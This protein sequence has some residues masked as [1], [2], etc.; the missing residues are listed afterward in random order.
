MSADGRRWPDIVSL[1]VVLVAAAVA[2]L[3]RLDLVEFKQDEAEALNNAWAMVSTGVIPLTAPASSTGI[4]NSPVITWLLGIPTLLGLDGAG[5]TGFLAAFTVAAAGLTWWVARRAWGTW[6]ALLAGLVVGTAFWTTIHTRKAWDVGLVPFFVALFLLCC[7][8]WL[9]DGSRWW[10]VGAAAA[11]AGTIQFHIS[12]VPQVGVLAIL[13]LA[14][15]WWRRL[16]WPQLVAGAGVVVLAFLPAIVAQALRGFPALTT[17]SALA[18]GPARIDTTSIQLAFSALGDTR[19]EILFGPAGVAD[20]GGLDWA[21]GLV[22]AATVTG[23]VLALVLAVP[24]LRRRTLPDDTATRAAVTG[25]IAVVA[26]LVPVLFYARY[27]HPLQLH[28]FLQVVPPAALLLAGLAAWVAGLG[29]RD[30]RTFAEIG[31]IALG[32]AFAMVQIG[33]LFQVLD[34][35]QT[36]WTEGGYAV[37][38][39]AW[40][41][42]IG[43]LADAVPPGAT[44]AI[45]TTPERH[46]V[47]GYFARG[48]FR[49]VFPELTEVAPARVSGD[50]LYWAA[51]DTAGPS[52]SAP[53]DIVAEAPLP[54]GRSII[55]TRQPT[56]PAPAATSEPLARFASGVD[57]LSAPLPERWTTGE[58]AW[59]PLTWRV[60]DADPARDHRFSVKLVSQAN[61]AVLAERDGIGWDPRD[62]Q[63]G[64]VVTTWFPLTPET[65]D[66]QGP[67]RL[68]IAMY[69]LQEPSRVT[70][71]AGQGAAFRNGVVTLAGPTRLEIPRGLVE[72]LPA[73][74]AGFSNGIRLEGAGLAIQPDGTATVLLGWSTTRQES[75]D[76]TVFVQALDEAGALE[77]Q[78]DGQPA[79]GTFPT[80]AWRPGELVLD[81]HALPWRP[82]QRLIAGLYDGRTGERVRLDSGAD[83]AELPVPGR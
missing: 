24:V 63:P 8:R 76:L 36:T 16:G 48:Q 69:T 3:A 20:L 50:P 73:V 30:W 4:I 18:G 39:G 33:L 9:A 5:I 54:G 52:R 7:Q 19:Y 67:A 29:G 53:G 44:V 71:T 65:G 10:F 21:N 43:T 68:E 79:R 28:Y 27:T 22:A 11:L 35:V 37:P 81:A 42:A 57:L 75:R 2:H 61:G 6:P 25:F 46:Q 77:A 40:R 60:G 32:S 59:I 78:S 41:D 83:F 14:G 49:P 23:L 64:D 47:Y 62:W 15:L 45:N 80:S 55:L 58:T 26:V 82:G 12:S 66:G 34:R 56:G 1:V 51:D 70:A 72:G 31:T 38:Y 17:G 13:V 74:G